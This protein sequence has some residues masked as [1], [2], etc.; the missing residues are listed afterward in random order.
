MRLTVE[1]D[2]PWDGLVRVRV[3]EA[4][5]V[6]W[7]LSLRV[8]GWADGAT[9]TADGEPHDAAA[10]T[11]ASVRRQWRVGDVVELALPMPVRFTAADERVDAVRGCLAIERGP[12]VYAVE[13]VDQAP[14]VRVDT[15]G[16]TAPAGP[17]SSAVPTSSAA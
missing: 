14:D 12:L 7:T 5:G 13:A 11:Y 10:G 3:E 4:S 9:L 17:G 1:T 15:C 8:P 16:W 6:G 2:Y